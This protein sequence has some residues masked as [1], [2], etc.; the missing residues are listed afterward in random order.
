MLTQQLLT[1]LN[2]NYCLLPMEAILFP[3]LG[4]P[5][6]RSAKYNNKNT[7]VGEAHGQPA[8]EGVPVL[9]EV[10][11]SYEDEEEIGHREVHREELRHG[12]VR[13]V[14]LPDQDHYYHEQIG[15]KR[16]NCKVS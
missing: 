10:Q 8:P 1:E 15:Q 7:L 3:G 16:C 11:G 5:G 9:H 4:R 13:S 12:P 14:P 2:A 6:K